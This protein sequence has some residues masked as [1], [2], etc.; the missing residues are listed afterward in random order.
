MKNF[1]LPTFKKKEAVIDNELPPSLPDSYDDITE[2]DLAIDLKTESILM[3]LPSNLVI[4]YYE[5]MTT[6]ELKEYINGHVFKYFNAPNVTY[7]KIVKYNSGN[8]FEIHDGDPKT[9]YLKRIIDTFNNG[10]N[11]I[12]LKTQSRIAKVSKSLGKIDTYLLPESESLKHPNAILPDKGKMK[13]VVTSGFGFISFGIAMA[14]MGITSLFLSFVFK[15]VLNKQEDFN[16]PKQTIE[17]PSS[18]IE[19]LPNATE[20][21]YISKVWFEKGKWNKSEK[22]VKTPEMEIIERHSKFVG[23]LNTYKSFVQKCYNKLNTFK[24]CDDDNVFLDKVQINPEEQ[25]KSVSLKNG[26]I[27]VDFNYMINPTENFKVE[28]VPSVNATNNGVNWTT[29]CNDMSLIQACSAN[30]N[31]KIEKSSPV[32][33]V[34]TNSNSQDI[35]KEIPVA[36]VKIQPIKKE[37]IKPVVTPKPIKINPPVVQPLP[38]NPIE[39]IKETVIKMDENIDKKLEV[40]DI[41]K[42]PVKIVKP[43]IAPVVKTPVTEKKQ[44]VKIIDKNV[45]ETL[46]L[47][48]L[49]DNILVE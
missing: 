30:I 15:S 12:F 39:K 45:P 42:E 41:K 26:I 11:V 24:D 16:I 6:K 32:I 38:V 3:K 7:Y 48:N 43:V 47:N 5:G 14:F 34:L 25:V 33:S 35:L 10:E 40:I 21:S 20:T 1:R 31:D 22:S 28:I 8:L 49:P 18:F 36:P 44:D 4:G 29:Y 23:K 17:L 19:K 2:E 13:S 37:V 9:S 27:K 46:N